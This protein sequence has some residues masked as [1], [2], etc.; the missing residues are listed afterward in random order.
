MGNKRNRTK[1]NKRQANRGKN[2]VKLRYR[3]NEYFSSYFRNLSVI[4]ISRKKKIITDG[5][6]IQKNDDNRSGCSKFDNLNVPGNDF[7]SDHNC[8]TETISEVRIIVTS[9]NLIF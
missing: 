7:V 4:N 9:D 3:F 1:K 2:I 8:N 5:L 6:K